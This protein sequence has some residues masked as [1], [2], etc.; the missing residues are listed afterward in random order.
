[1]PKG[2]GILHLHAQEELGRPTWWLI[3]R[4]WLLHNKG[5]KSKKKKDQKIDHDPDFVQIYKVVVLGEERSTPKRTV[6]G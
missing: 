5:K 4:S 6:P 2:L 3:F 1:M